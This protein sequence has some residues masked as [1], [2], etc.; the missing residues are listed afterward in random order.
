MPVVAAVE[1][2][3]QLAR[4]LHVGIG[5]QRMRDLVGVRFVDAVER[6]GGETRR[7]GLVEIGIRHEAST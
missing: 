2:Q 1:R 5:V 3:S 4:R 7:L 6:Q